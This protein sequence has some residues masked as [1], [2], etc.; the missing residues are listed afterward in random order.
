MSSIQ[1]IL[2]LL[3]IL[4]AAVFGLQIVEA[5]KRSWV[6]GLLM[7]VTAIFMVTGI[8]MLLSVIWPLLA[9]L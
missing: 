9:I 6:R 5:W 8:G 2:L 4:G 3:G 7:L 1:W